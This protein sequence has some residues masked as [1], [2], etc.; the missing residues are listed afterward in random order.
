MPEP[1]TIGLL[2]VGIGYMLLEN[3]KQKHSVIYIHQPIPEIPPDYTELQQNQP[4]T[5]NEIAT[6]T[7]EPPQIEPEPS[8][9]PQPPRPPQPPQPLH[10][11]AK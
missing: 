4:P 1:F 6:N 3:Y 7:N 11:S 5:Y 9:I 10:L 2:I 8:Q